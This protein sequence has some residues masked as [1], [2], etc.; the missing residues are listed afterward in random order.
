MLAVG[1]PTASVKECEQ[2]RIY[3]K[4]HK[5]NLSRALAGQDV[6]I[7]EVNEKVFLVSLMQ[8]D[9][10]YFDEDGNK[11]EPAENPFGP[12]VLPMSSE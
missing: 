8:Y 7:K 1:P 9:L 2:L 10:G 12:K 5:V 6:E 3:M 4:A 11:F